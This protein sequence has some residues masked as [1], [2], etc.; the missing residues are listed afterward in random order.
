[1]LMVEE[2]PVLLTRAEAA[3]LANISVSTLDQ[4]SHEPGCPVIRRGTRIVRFPRE[5]FIAW[6]AEL[7]TQS[8]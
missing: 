5:R 7:D 1:M 6:L 3:K 8:D 2:E 4:W